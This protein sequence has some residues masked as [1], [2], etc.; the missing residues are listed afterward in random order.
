MCSLGA[1]QS[2]PCNSCV[3]SG[4]RDTVVQPYYRE[5]WSNFSGALRMK[6]T[7]AEKVKP[8]FF[9]TN[10][11]FF[12]RSLPK[13]LS[14]FFCSVQLFNL[15]WRKISYDA[16]QQHRYAKFSGIFCLNYIFVIDA[17]GK[18]LISRSFLKHGVSAVTMAAHSLFFFKSNQ[19]FTA[20]ISFTRSSNEA[21]LHC[22]RLDRP[23][24]RTSD[25]LR[26]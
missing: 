12:V 1:I 10:R 24:N 11:L 16:M 26:R 9:G 22:V 5:L 6:L 8:F 15:I 20:L 18:Q 25:F 14:C 4:S 23:G 2:V 3:T 17:A 21:W 13:S 7:I 19:I